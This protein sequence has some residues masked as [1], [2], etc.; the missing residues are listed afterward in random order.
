MQK[1]VDGACRVT[2]AQ[3]RDVGRLGRVHQIAGGE[4]AARGRAQIAIDARPP[5]RRIH[6]ESAATRQL[7]VGNPVAGEDH[8]VAR[9]AVRGAGLHVRDLDGLHA[10]RADDVRHAV[11]GQNRGAM[12]S[13]AEPLVREIRLMSR[14]LGDHRRHGR[15]GVRQRQHG[16]ETDVLGAD[17]DRAPADGVMVQ[18]HE[19]LQRA[20]GQHAQRAVA[21][22]QAR[23]AR[24][25]ATAGGQQDGARR[26][27][28]DAAWTGEAQGAGLSPNRWPS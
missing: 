10:T 21:G 3:G 28:A 18:R 17:N 23:R 22:H 4:H 19:L 27:R 7:V 1:G 6:D 15:A 12:A 2:P 14:V 11:R 26:H 8:G 25:L 13:G 20:G 9:D 16:R 24:P 5:R